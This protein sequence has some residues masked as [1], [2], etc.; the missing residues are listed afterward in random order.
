MA[1]KAKAS[2]F[3]QLDI[4]SALRGK[5]VFV[6]EDEQE[7]KKE[8][9]KK[10]TFF[11][12]IN[13]IR[14]YKNGDMLDDEQNQ[15]A[16]NSYMVIRGLSAKYEDAWLCNYFN[17][18]SGVLTKKQL[19]LSLMYTIPKDFGFY[20]WIKNTS[21]DNSE[22]IKL[23]AKYFKCSE[24]EALEYVKIM[25]EEWAQKIKEKFGDFV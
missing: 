4:I 6:K 21:E 14:K 2:D 8:E 22:E 3:K 7:E 5:D 18:Y 25:G 12:F 1:R 10:L 15:T 13:D 17:K 20:K 11:D 24:K 19:Y 9:S 23:I 16:F